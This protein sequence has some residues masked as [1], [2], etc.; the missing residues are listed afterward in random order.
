M[1]H[2]GPG[3]LAERLV[4][5]VDAAGHALRL[6]AGLLVDDVL[7]DV[8]LLRVHVRVDGLGLVGVRRRGEQRKH[9]RDDLGPHRRPFDVPVDLPAGLL[10]VPGRHVLDELARGLLRAP[11][12]PEGRGIQAGLVGDDFDRIADGELSLPRRLAR[13][14]CRFEQTQVV[15]AS[16]KSQRA[17]AQ[18]V[19][20]AVGDRVEHTKDRVWRTVY[21]TV[22]ARGSASGHAQALGA[23]LG[24]GQ[25]HPS[26][27]RR[28]EAAI[29]AESG[30]RAAPPLVSALRFGQKIPESRFEVSCAT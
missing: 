20:A 24:V 30:R 10:A 15:R 5:D 2:G 27:A 1:G 22:R 9:A 12:R 21:T 25:G 19:G 14:P 8:R 17:V 3:D 13:H 4:R 26:R 18:R 16:T 28:P 23:S 29:D 6:G 11:A 7:V